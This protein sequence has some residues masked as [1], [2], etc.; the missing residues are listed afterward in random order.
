MRA[1]SRSLRLRLSMKGV[2]TAIAFSRP[3]ADSTSANCGM[4][5]AASFIRN[6]YRAPARRAGATKK[7]LRGKELG[8][9]GPGRGPGSGSPCRFPHR[10]IVCGQDERRMLKAYQQQN[11][12]LKGVLIG[13]HDE[14]PPT[15]VWLDLFNPTLE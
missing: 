9:Y 1:S 10:N 7:P 13:E 14:T 11:G 15:A 3:A 12:G 4:E 2:S 6:S 5:G 8:L